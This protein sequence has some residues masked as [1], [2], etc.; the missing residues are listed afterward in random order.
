MPN[1]YDRMNI[2]QTSVMNR[3]G[4]GLDSL[5]DSMTGEQPVEKVVEVVPENAL[6][7]REDGSK[8]F[9]GFVMSKRGLQGDGSEQDWLSLGDLLFE[10]DDQMQIW[11]GDWLMKGEREWGYTYQTMAQ[12]YNRSVGT[13]YNWRSV[14]HAV[15][16]SRRRENLTFSHYVE[17]A[18]LEAEYQDYWLRI[19]S[20]DGLSVRHLAKAI[21]DWLNPPDDRIKPAPTALPGFKDKTR[22]KSM[23][24]SWM[25][26]KNWQKGKLIL[27]ESQARQ[28]MLDMMQF[29]DEQLA[30]L[31]PAS[32]N[33]HYQE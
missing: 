32:D 27:S 21:E 22:V 14:C 5:M 13:L 26:I 16:F 28:E 29:L 6:I 30:A 7:A 15:D 8:V 20:E 11:L 19:A 24:T 4:A 33:R 25:R 1:E 12:R 3:P 23:D 2:R 9:K 18:G 10:F 17:V 31:P